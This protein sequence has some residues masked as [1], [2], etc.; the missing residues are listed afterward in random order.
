MYPSPILPE[1]NFEAKLRCHFISCVCVYYNLNY[2]YQCSSP[3][4]ELFISHQRYNNHKFL[5]KY[6]WIQ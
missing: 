3:G 5:D 6:L 4:I 1:N 2:Y